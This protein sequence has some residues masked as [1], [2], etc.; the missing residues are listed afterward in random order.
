V[1][2]K[3][4]FS[5]Q[6][7]KKI[8]CDAG[9]I[10]KK[11]LGNR[12]AYTIIEKPDRT[13]VTSIDLEIDAYLKLHLGKLFPEAAWVSEESPEPKDRVLQKWVWM[14]DPIDGTA[15]FVAHKT[16][17][18]ISVALVHE[19]RVRASGVVNPATDQG[20]V[21]IDD[22]PALFW[23]TKAKE[24]AVEFLDAHISLS[25]RE[26]RKG[27]TVQIEK[28]FRNIIFVSGAA[29]KLMRTAAGV[30][31]FYLTIESKSEWDVAAGLHLAECSGKV[32]AR[33]DGKEL[34]YN[35]DNLRIP[36]GII[37]GKKE[38]VEAFLKRYAAGFSHSRK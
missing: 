34:I 18:A 22:G 28:D 13:L 12:N 8:V 5:P 1:R 10:A 38:F 29:N 33:L 19:G 6:E 2:I 30:D 36:S 16:G 7:F 9:L 24:P 21:A 32:G 4:P 3:L 25:R 14:V 15:N 23:G 35:A 17:F 37:C 27:L 26:Q 31:D 11:A 20:G